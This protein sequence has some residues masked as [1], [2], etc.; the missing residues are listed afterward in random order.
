MVTLSIN[1]K[2]R[3]SDLPML[4]KARLDTISGD[5]QMALSYGMLDG[6]VLH[7]S[8]E[9]VLCGTSSMPQAMVAEVDGFVRG[10]GTAGWYDVKREGQFTWVFTCPKQCEGMATRPFRP[11]EIDNNGKD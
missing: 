9:F 5:R 8:I 4:V 2:A 1:D 11:E 10:L 3:Q 6:G 7:D